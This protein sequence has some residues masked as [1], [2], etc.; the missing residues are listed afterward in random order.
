[1]HVGGMV[2]KKSSINIAYQEIRFNDHVV[3]ATAS[4]WKLISVKLER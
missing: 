3:G 4:R 1:M 2:K